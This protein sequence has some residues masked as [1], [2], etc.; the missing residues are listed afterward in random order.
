MKVEQ[1]TTSITLCTAI[2]SQLCQHKHEP[3]SIVL[4]I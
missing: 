2:V 4:Y 3:V 1:L